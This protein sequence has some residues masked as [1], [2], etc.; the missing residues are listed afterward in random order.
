MKRAR[1]GVTL[2][3]LAAALAGPQGVLAA[4]P[5]TPPPA[6]SPSKPAGAPDPSEALKARDLPEAARQA[7]LQAEQG[8]AEGQFNLALFF[9]HGV[10]VPQN[11]QE[12]L[13]WITLSALADY[14]RS[15]AARAEMLKSTDPALAKTVMDWVRAR[16]VKEAEAG[17]NRALVLLS[18]SFAPQFGFENPVESY[19]WALLAVTA[20]Q[21]DAKRRR[22]SLVTSLKPADVIKT[23]DKAA[24]WYAKYRDG[25]A[26]NATAPK[27]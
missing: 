23:Q 11:Y 9:W 7:R 1:F 4:G 21:V 18:N 3:C 26:K 17:D 27:G 24:E 20:G 10:A 22:D 5:Q 19:Y 2:L 16:L 13:R 14:P 15:A 8:S 6:A 12:A 25:A